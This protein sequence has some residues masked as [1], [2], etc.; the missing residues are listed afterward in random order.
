M[1]RVKELLG[2]LREARKGSAD[3]LHKILAQF[4]IDYGIKRDTSEEYM[5]D[6]TEAGHVEITDGSGDW[7]FIEKP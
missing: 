3:D 6:I 5:Q 1:K 4:R 7:K 2:R